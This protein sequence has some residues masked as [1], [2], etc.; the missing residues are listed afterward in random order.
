M[1]DL[2]L[3]R[4]TDAIQRRLVGFLSV[5]LPAPHLFAFLAR[6]APEGRALE[7]QA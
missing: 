6:W 5:L 3:D 7:S 2:L 4:T 1:V